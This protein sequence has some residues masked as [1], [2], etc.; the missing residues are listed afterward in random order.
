MG[1]VTGLNSFKAYKDTFIAPGRELSEQAKALTTP[2]NT[3]E[4]I[5]YGFIDS[6]GSL[7]P[8]LPIDIMTGGATKV[9]LSGRILPQMEALLTTIPNFALGMGW[10]GMAEGI[11]NTEG[12]VVE[13]T[14]GGIVGAGESTA[15]GT[16]YAKAGVGLV[17]IG[18]MAA[19]GLASTFYNA[20]KEGRIPSQQE[21]IDGTTNAAML[22]MVFTVLPHIAEGSQIKQEKSVLRAY[23]KKFEDLVAPKDVRTYKIQ[24]DPS[25]IHKIASDLLTD[26]R[27]RPEIR[28]AL[29]KPFLDKLDQRGDIASPE[30]KLGQWKDQ[31]KLRMMR[32]TMERIIENSCGADAKAVQA[33]TTEKIKE[34]ETYRKRWETNINRL[35]QGE[36]MVGRGIKPNS[37][38]SA[39]TMRYGEGRMTEAELKAASPKN[40]ENI[41][42]AAAFS[43][44][45]YGETI[46]ALN[47]VREKY[48][49][50]PIE[51][52]VDYFRHFQEIS[53]ADKLFG[54]FLGGEKPPAS[55][56]GIISRTKYGKPF[57]STE[58]RRL[59]G[60][61]KEDAVLAL[62]NYVRATGPQLFHLDSV[63]RIRTLERYIRGQAIVNETAL[64]EG[65]PYVK[66]DASNFV[67]KLSI[68]ADMLAGQPSAITQAVTRNIDR[69]FVAGVRAIQRNVVLNMIGGNVA[70]S[71]MNLL[72]T[73]Q[74]VA[75][76]NP[77]AVVKGMITSIFHLERVKPFELGGVRSEFY[78]RRYPTGFLP[79]NWIEKVA[80]KGFILPNVIDRFMVQS[81]IAGKYHEGVAN[82]MKPAEAMKAADNYAARVVTDRTTGQIPSI[83]AEPDLQLINRFQVEINNLWSW[84]AHDVPKEAQGKL[85]GTVGRMA[86]FAIASTLINNVYEKMIGRRP[87]LDF[88]EILGTLAGVNKEGRDRPFVERIGPAFKTLAG[89]V[90][91]GNIFVAGGRF[92]IAS[93]FP[94][95][96]KMLD[97]PEHEMLSEFVKPL[98]FLLPFGGGGQAKKTLEGTQAWA[99]GYVATPSGNIRYEVQ[100]DFYNFVRGFLFGKNAFPEAVRYW[101]QPKSER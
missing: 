91:F 56:A 16:L 87:Q 88:I 31:S 17:G 80:E 78:D 38:D 62:Q 25:D 61:F 47:I 100:K 53:I 52:R 99:K 42:R 26:K 93:A 10:R 12:G 73:A 76:T 83:M 81:L 75:S 55:I 9:A 96:G 58:M 67:E 45:I 50:E 90:P 40:W 85:A 101:N 14:I 72:P 49:Y 95:V 5:Y 6:I 98:W 79:K 65:R 35:I 43:R 1:A 68:Y 33:E 3:A 21:M 54:H 20:A 86:V 60:E 44:R 22:G 89:N 28:E 71:F 48:E 19:L 34:N 94:D 70:A 15:F 46:D 97:D 36:E 18:K 37:K 23:S 27:I 51:K 92:P 39:L 69:P 64:A 57:S 7:I 13:K 11:Q 84:L 4:R 2:E 29:A 8:T 32:E 77:K 63:Q 82:G 66:V 41:K 74:Q 30:F 59:G 24:R